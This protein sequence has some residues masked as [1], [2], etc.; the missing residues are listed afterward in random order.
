MSVRRYRTMA[1]WHAAVERLEAGRLSERDH[2]VMVAVLEQ[3]L[4]P[5]AMTAREIR[6]H[7]R[8]AA[9]VES[10]EDVPLHAPLP[11]TPRKDEPCNIGAGPLPA[12]VR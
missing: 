10:P 8:E 6:E 3:E 4:A 2:R 12:V 11:F 9:G 7:L 5:V 1:W